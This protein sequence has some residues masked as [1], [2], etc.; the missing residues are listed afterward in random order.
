M[1][2][3]MAMAIDH[4][5]PDIELGHK[6]NTENHNM[7]NPPPL[8]PPYYQQQQQQNTNNNM[9]LYP[10]IDADENRRRWN[11][12][13]K[14]Y[15]ILFMQL[16]L[17]VAIAGV[18]VFYHPLALFL[19]RTPGLLIAMAFLPHGEYLVWSSGFRFIPWD[20]LLVMSMAYFLYSVSSLNSGP[21]VCFQSL[22]PLFACF[23]L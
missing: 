15:S 17:T 11:F 7:S 14:V 12:I 23:I 16:L 20:L 8:P 4:Q 5:N 1:A 22:F 10:N 9:M 6:N 21:S 18:V 13:R 2:M 3:A 19:V